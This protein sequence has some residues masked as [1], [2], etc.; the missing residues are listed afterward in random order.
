MNKQKLMELLEHPENLPEL[1][2]T[3]LPS[4]PTE[5]IMIVNGKRGYYPVRKSPTP[6]FAK[7]DVDYRNE[8][9]GVSEEAREALTILSM[10]NN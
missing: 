10:K 1:A 5:V 4:D 6:R 3:T 9:F 7:E 8:I 2:Y